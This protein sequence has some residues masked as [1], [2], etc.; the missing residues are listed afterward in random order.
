MYLVLI[1]FF[2]FL[3]TLSIVIRKYKIHSG[4]SVRPPGDERENRGV[5]AET[6]CA[7]EPRRGHVTF[8]L[9]LCGVAYLALAV[10]A[11]V[12]R[13]RRMFSG[14]NCGP[15]PNKHAGSPEGGC[16]RV[17]EL[18]VATQDYIFRVFFRSLCMPPPSSKGLSSTEQLAGGQRVLLG[19]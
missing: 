8:L 9:D 2:F 16:D 1:F 6:I 7:S 10:P 4:T 13:G 11:T 12:V 18:P 3:L 15:D 17:P 14:L 19:R 5:G